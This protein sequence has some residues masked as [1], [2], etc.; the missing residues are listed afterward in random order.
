MDIFATYATDT[1]A[2]AEG[3]WVEIGDA[4][5]LVARSGNPAYSK[6]LSRLYERNRKLLD[7]KDDNADALS[8][9]LMVEVLAETILLGWEGVQFKGA[10]LTYSVDNAKML[11]GIKDFRAQISKAAE[12][13]EA[14]KV[15]QEA[16]EVKN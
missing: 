14:Y 6:K 8:E 5:F 15:K 12:D 3:V 10:D 13:F 4:K 1:A 11:L 7:M 2:E 9:R 16:D